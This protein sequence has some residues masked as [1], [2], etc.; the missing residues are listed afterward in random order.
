MSKD[1]VVVALTAVKN[2]GRDYKPGEAFEIEASILGAHLTGGQ[3]RIAQPLEQAGYRKSRAE[4]VKAQA[5]REIAE[6]DK[7]MAEARAPRK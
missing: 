5:E 4:A 1:I 2:N 7:L 6:A 3:V